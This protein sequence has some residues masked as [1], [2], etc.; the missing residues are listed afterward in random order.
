[1]TAVHGPGTG[2][3]SPLKGSRRWPNA[4]EVAAW[5]GQDPMDADGDNIGSIEAKGQIDGDDSHERC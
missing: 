2:T 4:S 3:L 5:R 1:M